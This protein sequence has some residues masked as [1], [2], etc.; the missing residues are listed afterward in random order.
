MNFIEFLAMCVCGSLFLFF[1]LIRVS[2]Y[3]KKKT[4]NWY[5]RSESD[6]GSTLKTKHMKIIKDWPSL[7]AY[8]YL[9]NAIAIKISKDCNDFVKTPLIY[10]NLCDCLSCVNIFY[11]YSHVSIKL[12]VTIIIISNAEG[13]GELTSI[14]ILLFIV[15]LK[16]FPLI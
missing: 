16:I 15:K 1:F 11:W 10:R 8:G 5:W 3:Q 6:T 7:D 2:I 4:Q 13:G 12:T 14:F 9:S